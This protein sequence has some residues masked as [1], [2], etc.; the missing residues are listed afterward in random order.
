MQNDD[1]LFDFERARPVDGV[2][3]D[4]YLV[5][6]LVKCLRGRPTDRAD[7]LALLRSA[8][9]AG[10]QAA[11][12]AYADEVF[13]GAERISMMI[14]VAEILGMRRDPRFVHAVL[15]RVEREGRYDIL[16][17][18]HLETADVLRY[19]P[20]H[21]RR[22]LEACVDAS[23]AA[24]QPPGRMWGGP[25][26][27]GEAFRSLGHWLCDVAPLLMPDPLERVRWFVHR[28]CERVESLHGD[29]D[30]FVVSE[31]FA[32]WLRDV[33]ATEKRRALLELLE[34]TRQKWWRVVGDDYV[35]TEFELL[36][37]AFRPDDED[38][39]HGP[40]DD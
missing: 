39:D 28:F 33:N 36:Q 26:M 1:D 3:L 31:P 10:A 29:E 11:I 7:A 27:S 23:V 13:S 25:M 40:D 35:T 30:M 34:S 4:E 8:G 5:R 15:A 14:E 38:E 21:L 17:G 22:L 20:G 9:W 16:D 32:D 2:Y 12:D 19:D 24:A 37:Q 6:E 18:Q